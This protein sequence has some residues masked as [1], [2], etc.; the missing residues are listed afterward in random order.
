MRG[1]TSFSEKNNITNLELGQIQI[2]YQTCIMGSTGFF[3]LLIFYK[4]MTTFYKLWIFVCFFLPL[5]PQYHHDIDI[6][7][8]LLLMMEVHS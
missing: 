4:S 7:A 8:N 5:A 2:I 3:T 6:S 1:H